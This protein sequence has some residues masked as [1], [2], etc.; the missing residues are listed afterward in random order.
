M[1]YE[2]ITLASKAVRGQ[3]EQ[4][5]DRTD[6]AGRMPLHRETRVVLVHAHARSKE[7]RLPG[8]LR[9]GPLPPLG[10]AVLAAVLRGEHEVRLLDDRVH[11]P[12]EVDEGRNNFV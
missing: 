7:G 10:L 4:I 11:S 6:L 2:V 5:I 3:C 1:L 12:A 8:G 9:R